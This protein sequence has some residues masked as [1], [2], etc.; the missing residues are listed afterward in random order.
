M[1][2]QRVQPFLE[3]SKREGKERWWENPS[4]MLMFAVQMSP[5]SS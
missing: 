5:S 4:E 3:E 2:V 1:R